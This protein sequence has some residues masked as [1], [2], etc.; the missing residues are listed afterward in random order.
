MNILK[1][2]EKQIFRLW[3]SNHIIVLGLLNAIWLSW[4]CYQNYLWII[5]GTSP[6]KPMD[7]FVLCFV[8]PAHLF[9]VIHVLYKFIICQDHKVTLLY[10]YLFL[11]DTLYIIYRMPFDM[12]ST[13]S[14]AMHHF[15]AFINVGLLCA[16]NWACFYNCIRQIENV[17][18]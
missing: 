9:I 18:R 2:M 12:N 14:M 13:E 17:K 8:V 4:Q 5:N 1:K 3:L 7:L 16:F 6:L 10:R 11:L 15:I